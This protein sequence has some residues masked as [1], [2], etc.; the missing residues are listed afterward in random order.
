MV[1]AGESWR[2]REWKDRKA[3][4]QRGDGAAQDRMDNLPVGTNIFL[5]YAPE[6]RRPEDLR[7][8]RTAA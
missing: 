3:D 2:V 8:L 1:T 5:Q 7:T 6:R 4:E